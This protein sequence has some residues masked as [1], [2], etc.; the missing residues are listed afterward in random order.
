MV[1]YYFVVIYVR[2]SL[3]LLSSSDYT[4]GLVVLDGGGF[5]YDDD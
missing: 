3:F 1:K 2:F 4:N 5:R